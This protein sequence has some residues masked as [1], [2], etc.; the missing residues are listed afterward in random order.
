MP[1]EQEIRAR[2]LQELATAAEI[3]SSNQTAIEAEQPLLLQQI[4]TVRVGMEARDAT[5]QKADNALRG[6]RDRI[7]AEFD[8]ARGAALTK[9]SND[10]RKASEL[11]EAE[12]QAA[13]RARKV[14]VAEAG[15]IYD[16]A[17]KS[18]GR[19][20]GA[21]KDEAR[22]AAME[23]RDEA[24]E[25]AKRVYQEA[26]DAARER[27]RIAIDVTAKDEH[28]AALQA[29]TAKAEESRDKAVTRH[30]NAVNAAEEALAKVMAADPRVKA[31]EADCARRLE[32]EDARYQAECDAIMERQRRDL[33]A[34]TGGGTS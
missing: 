18:A 2:T 7:D 3:H 28:D 32:Q 33:D 29:A 19:L 27:A 21:E 17:Y 1:T 10:G 5:V 12:T 16:E 23:A 25:T 15:R 4:P 30:Q 26:V 6:A 9:E 24:I 11:C 14:Q 34:L 22:R 13:E 8:K 31:V 20:V